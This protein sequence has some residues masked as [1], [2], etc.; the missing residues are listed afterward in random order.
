MSNN[1]S[2]DK[3]SLISGP[4]NLAKVLSKID[5]M[6]DEEGYALIKKYYKEFLSSSILDTAFD[7]LRSSTKFINLL[8]QVCIDNDLSYEQ[9][10]F[11]NSMIYNE[12][13]KFNDKKYIQKLYF[14]LGMVV[15]RS[16]TNRIMN[17]GIDSTLSIYLAVARKSSLNKNTNISRLN[18]C[19]MCSDPRVMTI[20]RITDLYCE[21]FH[22]KEDIRE[23]FLNIAEDNYVYT[24]DEEWITKDI[25]KI[26]N[27][28]NIAILSILDS[29]D[30]GYIEI[31]LEEYYKY[32]NMDYIDE[33]EV[34]ISFKYLDKNVYHNISLIL[35]RLAN[36]DI[37]LP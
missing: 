3:N 22:T 30:L 19:I 4:I 34:R 28:I 1:T 33:N 27:N 21:L 7:K 26:A 35:D 18:F 36:K 6:S 9:R 25:L 15:N 2:L 24:S 29:L 10:V 32:I 20:Q 16:V 14:I 17:C 12:L 11:C 8:I 13:I 5:T 23:L 37:F 31:I